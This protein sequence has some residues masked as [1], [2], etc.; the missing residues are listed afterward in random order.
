MRSSRLVMAVGMGA[1]MLACERAPETTLRVQGTVT[2][3]GY[4]KPV[5]AAD[6]VI[7]WPPQLGGG[8]STLH[9]DAEGH[10]VAGRTVKKRELDCKGIVITVRASGFASAYNNSNESCDTGRLNADFKLFPIPR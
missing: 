10:F 4:A 2:S 7:E 1:A 5:R 8:S 9:T 6:V 3:I